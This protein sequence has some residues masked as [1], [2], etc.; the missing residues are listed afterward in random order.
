MTVPLGVYEYDG[1]YDDVYDR[2]CDTAVAVIDS[3]GEDS[4]S[5]ASGWWLTALGTALGYSL[6]PRLIKLLRST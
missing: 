6:S 1:V 3:A 5:L 4:G 2:G